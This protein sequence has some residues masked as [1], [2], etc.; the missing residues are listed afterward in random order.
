[1]IKSL[2]HVF[3]LRISETGQAV[4][5]TLVDTA[6]AEL[7]SLAEP[8]LSSDIR[9]RSLPKNITLRTT[10]TGPIPATTSTSSSTTFNSLEADQATEQESKPSSNPLPIVPLATETSSN[11]TKTSSELQDEATSSQDTGQE[12]ANDSKDEG[13]LVRAE[14]KPGEE[15]TSRH[16]EDTRQDEPKD[17]TLKPEDNLSPSPELDDGAVRAKL[18]GGSSDE[19][20]AVILD[21][22]VASGST[23]HHHEDI[24]SFS[25]WAQ[26]RLEE[27]EKKKS[28]RFFLPPKFT[29]QFSFHPIEI[30]IFFSIE[31]Q[32]LVELHFALRSQVSN[33]INKKNNFFPPRHYL[34]AMD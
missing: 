23:D 1:M 11:A 28:K 15:T 6:A 27:A 9:S 8:R 29:L 10:T 17:E 3:V 24:P 32:K 26:K 2:R 22:L 34:L 33:E 20:A 5:L 31:H 19:A 21:G 30:R 14:Q 4:V 18:G 7:Q 12:A 13:V 25:E 16:P